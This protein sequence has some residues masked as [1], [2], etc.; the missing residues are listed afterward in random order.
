MVLWSP[1]EAVRLK[2]R[3]QTQIYPGDFVRENMSTA[4][5]SMLEVGAPVTSFNPNGHSGTMVITRPST[6]GKVYSGSARTYSLGQYH[7]NYLAKIG[8]CATP[9]YT[10][11]GDGRLCSVGLFSSR[12]SCSRVSPSKVSSEHSRLQKL[13][14]TSDRG[15]GLEFEFVARRD[16]G[17]IGGVKRCFYQADASLPKRNR[18][19]W[20]WESDGS[21][22]PLTGSEASS[23]GASS[24]ETSGVSF[25]VT[26]PAPPNV[27]SGSTGFRA[28][29]DVLMVLRSMGIQAGPTCGLHVHVNVRGRAK[30]S[31][32]TRKQIAYVWA[33]Y[34]RYQFS[35]H[36]MLS[37]SRVPTRYARSLFLN[38]G[39]NRNIFEQLHKWVRGGSANSGKSDKEFCNYVLGGGRSRPCEQRRPNVRYSQVNLVPVSKYGTIEFRG[40]SATYDT[41]R[42]MRWVSFLVGFVERFGKGGGSA[43]GMSKY[44]GSSSSSSDYFKLQKAQQ[45]HTMKGLYKQLELGRPGQARKW[46]QTD[47]LSYYGHGSSGTRKWE[48]G[49]R[50]CNPGHGGANTVRAS[51][52]NGGGGRGGGGGGGGFP[53]PF[54]F[55]TAIASTDADKEFVSEWPQAYMVS[56]RNGTQYMRAQMPLGQKSDT[57]LE[58]QMPDGDVIAELVDDDSIKKGYVEFNY[59]SNML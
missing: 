10:K 18:P 55:G 36:E 22:K 43:N 42:V 50:H 5:W 6:G 41:E 56:E 27:L 38:G 45:T 39:E 52:S 53:F 32:L 33:A 8:S 37:P 28:A 40:H 16:A 29:I 7:R 23:L 54:P 46:R 44:F 2:L 15:V 35:I 4:E 34:A 58:V 14:P 26:S 25:E 59:V 13:V 24:G 21:V 57:Y 3:K 12:W 19:K 17:S 51:C 31:K 20:N 9:V 11:K 30:G 47:F 1:L 49:D 48:R